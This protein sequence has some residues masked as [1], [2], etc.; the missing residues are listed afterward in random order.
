MAQ[1]VLPPALQE[2]LRRDVREGDAPV[3]SDRDHGV[4]AAV[5]RCREPV[6]LLRRL[7]DP[8]L[9]PVGHLVEGAR[10]VVQPREPR[11]GHPLAQA[12]LAHPL[13]SR[14][15]APRHEAERDQER[16]AH[17]E[18]GPDAGGQ[19]RRH[20]AGEFPGGREED[21]QEKKD[22]EVAAGKPDE[23]PHHGVLPLEPV[24]GAAQR[25]QARRLARV[26]LDLLAQP[27]HVDVNG[28]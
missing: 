7:L 6:P 25:D 28:A 8:L 16:G 10:Q 2:P 22:G 4:D 27:A 5:Q 15:H 17:A 14:P 19:R 13:G 26:L 20:V 3:R 23:E 1:Q 18:G 11:R 12:S 24:A 9:Q 21:E